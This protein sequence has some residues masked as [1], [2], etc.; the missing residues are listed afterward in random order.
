MEIIDK[1]SEAFHPKALKYIKIGFCYISSVII[2]FVPYHNYQISLQ[3][4]LSLL[5]ALRPI[6]V[7]T[8]HL[9]Y[10]LLYL[11]PNLAISN[12]FCNSYYLQLL[13]FV[14]FNVKVQSFWTYHVQYNIFPLFF[15]ILVNL[16]KVGFQTFAINIYYY[17]FIAIWF[18]KHNA[19]YT[20]NS[21]KVTNAIC[22][23]L[24]VF[25]KLG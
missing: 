24:Q 2:M 25:L 19:N 15:V 14:A 7:L 17:T 3:S 13:L 16:V 11:C 12:C 10:Y 5:S 6:L 23:N 8:T 1:N 22:Q 18:S 21:M 20:W 4:F 9:K